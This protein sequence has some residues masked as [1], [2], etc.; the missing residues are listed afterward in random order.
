MAAAGASRQQAAWYKEEGAKLR[1]YDLRRL[2]ESYQRFVNHLTVTVLAR[3]RSRRIRL[4][5]SSR[6]LQHK[7]LYHKASVWQHVV[8]ADDGLSG[9]NAFNNRLNG[10]ALLG[11]TERKQATEHRRVIQA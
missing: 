5:F 8:A 6:L 10:A 4:G 2:N 1:G 9:R 7:S 11:L 3:V